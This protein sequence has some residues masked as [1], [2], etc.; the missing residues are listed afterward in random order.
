MGGCGDEDGHDTVLEGGGGDGRVGDEVA[1]TVRHCV[2]TRVVYD[3]SY[4]RVVGH[5]DLRGN[6]LEFVDD[7][8]S[9]FGSRGQSK[10][11][12]LTSYV[13]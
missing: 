4:V 7:D 2:I 10:S 9:D 12:Y 5:Q 1:E 8:D 11:D 6:F 13:S 3:R